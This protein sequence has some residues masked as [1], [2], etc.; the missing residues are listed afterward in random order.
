MNDFKQYLIDNYSHNELADMANHGCS[1]GIGGMI[2]YRDTVPLYES[3]RESIHATV[4]AYRDA[5]DDT[6]KTLI[7]SLDI[8]EVFANN[9]LWFAAEW[10]AQEITSGEYMPEVTSA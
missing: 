2:Y 9:M 7:D 3:Y 1:G 4:A 8:Y 6:P 10:L 5:T